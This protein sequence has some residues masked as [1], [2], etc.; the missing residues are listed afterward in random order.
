MIDASPSNAG[1]ERILWWRPSFHYRFARNLLCW[2]KDFVTLLNPQEQRRFIIRKS[3]VLWR[4]LA[5]KFRGSN[6]TDVDLDEIIDVN[7]FPDSELK[8]WQIHLN[9]LVAH[10]ERPYAGHVT[11]LR[12]RGQ[13]I[14][15]SFADD[16]CWGK[17]ARGGVTVK[18]IPG[19]HE[20]IF[21][22]P[23]VKFLAEQIEECLAETMPKSAATQ[24]NLSHELV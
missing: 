23:N 2:F 22:E 9:A 14:F 20:N 1:Y 13:P 12:T 16:F 10:V 7:H 24:K 5:A 18:Q 15:C 4:K 3:R 21:V 11:L 8:F 6:R 17:L 19:S